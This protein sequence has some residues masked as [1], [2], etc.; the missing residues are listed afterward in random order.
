MNIKTRLKIQNGVG[1]RAYEGEGINVTKEE[2][3]RLASERDTLLAALKHVVRRIEFK[4]EYEWCRAGHDSPEPCGDTVAYF[5]AK[6][7]V[8]YAEA[9][10]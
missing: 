6:A 5:E 4:A 7:A 10:E 1:E 9:D 3:L 8:K 2:V